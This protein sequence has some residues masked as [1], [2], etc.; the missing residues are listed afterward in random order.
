[1]AL[2]RTCQTEASLILPLCF[3][4]I[5]SYCAPSLNCLPVSPL[6]TMLS[7][8]RA[9]DSYK[10]DTHP[11]T[12]Q[13]LPA[14]IPSLQGMRAVSQFRATNSLLSSSPMVLSRGHQTAVTRVTLKTLPSMLILSSLAQRLATRSLDLEMIWEVC[15]MDEFYPRHVVDLIAIG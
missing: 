1:M 5:C 2:W 9:I 15:Q 3:C 6:G 11:M 7:F 14:Y 13:K 8:G 4:S 12:F 10:H